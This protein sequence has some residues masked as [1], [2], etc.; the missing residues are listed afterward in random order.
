MSF[1][2]DTGALCRTIIAAVDEDFWTV[3]P[4]ACAV[5]GVLIVF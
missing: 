2:S 3:G 1:E 4:F 5:V